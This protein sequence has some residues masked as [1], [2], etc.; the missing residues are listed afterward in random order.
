MPDDVYREYVAALR[1]KAKTIPTTLEPTKRRILVEE[2]GVTF[3]ADIFAS[4]DG[5]MDLQV[6]FVANN[7]AT[8]LDNPAAVSVD[9]DFR[10]RL[11]RSNIED[12][13]KR[14]LIDLMDLNQLVGRPER[15]AL[16]GQILARTDSKVKNITF[17]V[18]QEMILASSPTITKIKL[19]NELHQTMDVQQVRETLKLLP[20][21]YKEITTGYGRPQLE[22]S[23]ENRTLAEWLTHR[24]VISS[25]GKAW[26]GDDIVINLYRK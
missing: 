21:P 8:Y 26:W 19:L 18:A 16:V 23:D 22:N 5:D 14:N 13:Y 12:R 3:D 6:V 24:K 25:F 9:D 2:C 11:L 20:R 17:E 10:E 4:L 1:N 15:A 7:I